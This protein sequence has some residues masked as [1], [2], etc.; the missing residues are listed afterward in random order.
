MAI[1]QYLDEDKKLF[2]VVWH[3][4]VEADEWF[5]YAAKLTSHPAWSTT[6]RLLADLRFVRDTSTIGDEEIARAGYIFAKERNGLAGKQLAV[7]ARDQFGKAR[8]FGDL[9]ARFG[10]ALVVF[11]NLDTACVFLGVE[12]GYAASRLH[13]MRKQFLEE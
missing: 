4:T 8:R 3:G 13:E 7:V 10:V 6:P 11:N 2:F 9:I 1:I 5:H 12:E